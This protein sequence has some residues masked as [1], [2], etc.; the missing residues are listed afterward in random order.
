M[1]K[2][3]YDAAALENGEVR[4]VHENGRVLELAG[5]HLHEEGEWR[6]QDGERC[7]AQGKWQ[8][9]RGMNVLKDEAGNELARFDGED[10]VGLTDWAE[11][12]L[13]A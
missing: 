8:R 4:I 5:E 9:E 3:S 13:A 2:T 11:K 7:I 6:A 10:A 12:M 1:A